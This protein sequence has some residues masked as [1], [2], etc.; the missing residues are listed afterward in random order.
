MGKNSLGRVALMS[1][2]P[3]FA[4]A[5][6]SGEKVVEFRKRPVADDVTHV[7]IYATMPIGSLLGWFAIRGQKTMSP[8]ALWSAFRTVGGISRSGFFE[9]F[10]QR[11]HGTGILVDRA[12]RFAEPVPL[13]ELGVSL[14]APQSFQYLTAPQADTFFQMLRAQSSAELDS[15]LYP[16]S[17][18]G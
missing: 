11:E 14:R 2:R 17:R 13:T 1:I 9:Y 12:A 8:Q 18:A 6:L 7:L 3:E 5:I 4:D 16:L 10:D 15:D